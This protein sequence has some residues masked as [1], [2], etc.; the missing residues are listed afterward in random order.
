MTS[1]G[2]LNSSWF[3]NLVGQSSGFLFFLIATPFLIEALGKDKFGALTLLFLIPQ[4]VTQLDFGVIATGTRAMAM[5][6]AKG[7]NIYRVRVFWESL[8]ALTL[9]GVIQAVLFNTFSGNIMSVLQIDEL[10]SDQVLDIVLAISI[11]II[12]SLMAAGIAISARA[13]ERFKLLAITQAFTASTFWIGAW[14]LAILK[15]DMSLIIWWGAIVSAATTLI[16]LFSVRDV[17]KPERG[18]IRCS[19]S[20]LLFGFIRFSTGA[21]IG[22]ASSLLTYHA[23]KFLVSILISPSAVGIY[24]AC[25]SIASKILVFVSAI[26]AFSFPR[27]ARLHSQGSED[28]LAD[29]YFRATRLCVI[30]AVI[31]GIP[32]ASLAD[33]FLRL[34]LKGAYSQQYILVLM[35]MVM[36]YIFAS[37]SVVA[38]NVAIG[39]GRSRIPAIFAVIGGGVTLLLCWLLATEFGILGAVIASI[40]GMSQALVFNWIVATWFNESISKK[41]LLLSVKSIV[42]WSVLTIVI[43]P[44]ASFIGSWLTLILSAGMIISTVLLVWFKLGFA[45]KDEQNF[46]LLIRSK[47]KW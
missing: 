17:I 45:T 30:V 6:E 3:V 40:I 47:I 15:P 27:A 1:P 42:L 37:F 46:I 26:A 38:S 2:K 33:P 21:F 28:E 29:V 5:Y 32:L 24:N 14:G 7:K 34:W 4:I 12:F 43:T 20:P 13:F 39:M 11:W 36:G 25:A 22:Q 19:S 44:L 31:I 41:V 9:I 18:I 35:L 8:L 16:L 10:L 23:D